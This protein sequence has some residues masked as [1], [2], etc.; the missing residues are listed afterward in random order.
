MIGPDIVV[1]VVRIRRDTVKLGI[2]AP[3]AV[4]VDREEVR[5]RVMRDGRRKRKACRD[6]DPEGQA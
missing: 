3:A 5:E 6:I 1:T 2:T 4:D